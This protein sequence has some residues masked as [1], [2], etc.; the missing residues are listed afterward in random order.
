MRNILVSLSAIAAEYHFPAM[1]WYFGHVYKTPFGIY[2]T[3]ISDYL[4]RRGLLLESTQECEVLSVIFVM[5]FRLQPYRKDIIIYY[6]GSFCLQE[7]PISR[8]GLQGWHQLSDTTIMRCQCGL[9]LRRIRPIY[10][11]ASYA[12]SITERNVSK[13]F[14]KS[15][16][17][18]C[19][20]YC[21]RRQMISF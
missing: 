15:S 4:E 9:L 2:L 11:N 21:I 19:T 18:T 8:I 3:L 1:V 20:T 13:T 14:L 7:L 10:W 6:G 12:N 17:C 16:F 5:S